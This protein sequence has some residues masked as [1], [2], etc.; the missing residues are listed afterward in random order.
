MDAFYKFVKK[1]VEGFS[2]ENLDY[3]L[4]GALA[5]SFYG[6]PR[7]TSDVDIMVATPH[8]TDVKNKVV[9]ALEHAGLKIDPH[10]IDE[11]LASGYNI[12]TV[13]DKASPFTV[14]VIFSGEPIGKQAGTVAGLKTFFQSPEGL[15]LAKLRMIKATLPRERAAKDE[16]DIRAV[17]MFSKVNMKEVRNQAEK[18]GTLTI[19]DALISQ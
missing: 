19:F 11:A 6:V 8:G 10:K 16:E 2:R 4:T 14:D 3:A 5:A 18:D 13:A 7:T 15:I 9:K 12:A 1:L 17:L